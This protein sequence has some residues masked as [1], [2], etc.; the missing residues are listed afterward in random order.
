MTRIYLA[1]PFFNPVQKVY[2]EGLYQY[3]IQKKY[4]VFSPMHEIII[5]KDAS[6][7]MLADVFKQNWTAISACDVMVANV[8]WLLPEGESIQG[9]TLENEPIK[10]WFAEDR[11]GGYYTYTTPPLNITD[12]GVAFEIGFAF[13]MRV[14]VIAISPERE[15][16]K[17]SI[18]VMLSQAC[19]GV[20]YKI[21]ELPEAIDRV[22]DKGLH[23][24][25]WNAG[26][27]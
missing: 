15:V 5:P 14:P 23:H 27:F 12:T 10:D 18:N 2:V 17:S 1:A 19:A 24:S 26:A 6:P 3:L 16:K 13:A 20:C 11:M 25:E 8:D 4:D 21:T 22:V 7:E 9:I